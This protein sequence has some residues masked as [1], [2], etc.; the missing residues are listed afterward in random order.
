MSTGVS[1]S[2]RGISLRTQVVRFTQLSC[3]STQPGC[4]SS[5]P[6]MR[7]ELIPRQTT[8][9][10]ACE[11]S[12]TLPW[13]NRRRSGPAC[14]G[15]STPLGGVAECSHSLGSAKTRRNNVAAE[16][17]IRVLRRPRVQ[18]DS[19]GEARRSRAGLA[20]LLDSPGATLDFLHDKIFAPLGSDEPGTGS[21]TRI[22][23]VNAAL[24]FE[25]S[26]QA[27]IGIP[28]LRLGLTSNKR[29]PDST[30]E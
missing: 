27:A 1:R 21:P 14:D 12:F 8:G 2:S 13:A 5:L 17:G 18:H 19:G 10:L 4:F 7:D 20:V 30:C 24:H 11:A 22:L 3:S 25:K 23:A 15:A 28:R 29:H 16:Q 26:L 9:W 6:L